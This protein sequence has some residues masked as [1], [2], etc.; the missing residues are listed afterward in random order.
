MFLGKSV[1]LFETTDFKASD[2]WLTRFKVRHAIT[3][4]RIHGEAAEID[5]EELRDW[6]LNVLQPVIE[7]YAPKDIYNLDETGLF[8]QLL[9]KWTMSF[10]GESNF[11]I[12]FLGERCTTGK[13]SKV[14]VTA[15]LCTNMDGSDK[16]PILIIG[17]SSSPRCFKGQLVPTAYEANTRAWM[18]SKE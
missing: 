2:G 11:F 14:R 9:P 8:Y 12:K 15:L 5:Q 13:H 1:R 16:R 4:K 18:T 6:Q 10:R 7:Q 17:K 3:F